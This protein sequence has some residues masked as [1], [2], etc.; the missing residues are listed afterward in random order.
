M[1]KANGG[2]HPVRAQKRQP[3]A[4]AWMF[5]TG[6]RV[7]RS[8]GLALSMR[9]APSPFGEQSLFQDVLFVSA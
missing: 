1:M 5:Y 4:F 2:W 7:L 9:A 3:T 6:V 8:Y